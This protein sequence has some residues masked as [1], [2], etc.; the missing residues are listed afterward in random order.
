VPIS[1]SL[2]DA[3]R[4]HCLSRFLFPGEDSDHLSPQWVG[5][6]VSDLMPPGWSMHKLR[7]MYGT[8]PFRGSKK[9]G[10]CRCCSGTNR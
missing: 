5:I 4:S 8:R 9:S 3:I 10:P 2:A 7:T 6:L 1:D